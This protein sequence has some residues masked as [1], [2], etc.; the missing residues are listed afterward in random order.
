LEESAGLAPGELG[1]L[2]KWLVDF[3]NNK[4]TG[5]FA[6]MLYILY[7]TLTIIT[8]LALSLQQERAQILEQMAHI[9]RMIRGHVSQQTYQVQ[10]GG[11]TVTQGPYP[12]LQRR[13]NGQNNC[14]RIAADELEFIVQG[15]EGHARFQQLAQRYAA[16][17]EQLTWEQ[18]GAELKKN[19]ALLAA[20]FPQTALC[21]NRLVTQGIGDFAALERDLLA[22]LKHDG[23]RWLE[24]L[25]NDPALPGPH[26]QRR[27]DEE[28]QGRRP[29][30]VLLT[31]GWITLRR[32]YLYSAERGEGR[33]PLDGAL[34][35]VESYSPEVVRWAC[36][37]AALA[38]SYQAASQDL[39]SLAGLALDARQ[40]QRLVHQVAPAMHR[41]RAA[42][43]PVVNPAAGDI[44]CLGTDGTGAPMRRREVR[45][46]KGKRGGRARTREVK[47]ATVFTHRKPTQPDQRPER[48]YASTT[49]LAAIVPADQFG[50]LLRAEAI[51]RGLAKAKVVVFLGD[52]AAWVWKLAR[53]NFPQAVC[54]LDYYHACEHLTLLSAALYGEGSALAKRRFRQWRKALLKDKIAQ[55][56]AQ[57]KTDLPTNA[58]PRK[59]AQKQIAYFERNRAKMLYQTFRAA[60]Y[61]IGSGVVE[62]GCKTVVGQRFKQSGMLWSRKG[63][64]HLLTVRCALLSGWFADFWKHYNRAAQGLAFAA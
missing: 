31:L 41:W 61:F 33:F 56:I 48:D 5:L 40:I 42:Q 26:Q 6:G 15:V 9:D 3:Q 30:V 17:T 37:A 52:G 25:L 51:R 54:I 53:L 62:A 36:R 20:Y 59:L 39:L 21:L 23:A 19:P 12:L 4:K 64:S 2:K 38:G 16:L 34:G 47:V 46:R 22:A 18:Q 43:A 7:T 57:A 32:P 10:R 50:P 55:V 60:G 1:C 8:M 49:Y 44:M 27:A 14:Q 63:A 11:R 29:K 35:L 28:S 58:A 24:Q 45:G 13:E